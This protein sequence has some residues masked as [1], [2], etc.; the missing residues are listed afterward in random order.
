MILLREAAGRGLK[1]E[2]IQMLTGESA[3]AS[4]DWAA[5]ESKLKGLLDSHEPAKTS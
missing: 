3:D 4:I 1:Q 5:A 2:A